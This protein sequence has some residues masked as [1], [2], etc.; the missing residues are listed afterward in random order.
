METQGVQVIAMISIGGSRVGSIMSRLISELVSI[1]KDVSIISRPS[2]LRSFVPPKSGF[3]VVLFNVD[4]TDTLINLERI[5]NLNLYSNV[6]VWSG[7]THKRYVS[8][9]DTNFSAWCIR[10]MFNEGY[11]FVAAKQLVASKSVAIPRLINQWGA[12]S[13]T[14]SNIGKLTTSVKIGRASIQQIQNVAGVID[15]MVERDEDIASNVF[16]DLVDKGLL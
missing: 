5:G 4:N 7:V 3:V 10:N 13:V 12:T 14:N 8:I 16:V 11:N 15:R 2:E 1:G 9:I 6:P